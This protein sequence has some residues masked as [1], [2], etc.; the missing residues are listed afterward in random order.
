VLDA[1]ELDQ[2]FADH[3]HLR[4]FRQEVGDNYAGAN[5]QDTLARYL[6]NEPAPRSL[7][8]NPFLDELRADDRVGKHWQWV[9]VVRKRPLSAYLRCAFEWGYPANVRAGAQ[10]KVLDLTEQPAPPGF[11]DEEFWTLDQEAGLHM[12]YD[13]GEFVGAEPIKDVER[14]LIARDAA[15]T[16]AV[17]LSRYWQTHPQYHRTRAA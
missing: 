4:A 12:L 9:H 15:W 7:F 3:F 2:F 6:N 17:P 1:R 14:Y 13:H 8:E 10:V 16:S 5:E 11:I